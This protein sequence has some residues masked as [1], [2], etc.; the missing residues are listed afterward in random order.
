MKKKTN[1]NFD[2]AKLHRFWAVSKVL[3]E[4]FFEL[5]RRSGGS[6]TKPENGVGMLS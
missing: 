6:A 3:E 4:F 5:L 1:F 2:D